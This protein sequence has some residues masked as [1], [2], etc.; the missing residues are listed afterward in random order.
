MINSTTSRIASQKG[1]SELLDGGAHCLSR[2]AFGSVEDDGDIVTFSGQNAAQEF[3]R[4]L[5]LRHVSPPRSPADP[6]CLIL[7]EWGEPNHVV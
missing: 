6:R 3:D 5:Q 7:Q 4:L 2:R 1:F